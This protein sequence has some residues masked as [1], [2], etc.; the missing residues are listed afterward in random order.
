MGSITAK[1]GVL[2]VSVYGPHPLE[3]RCHPLHKP[4]SHT[5][6]QRIVPPH[7]G[8][9]NVPPAA[10][11]HIISGHISINVCSVVAV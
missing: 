3:F 1:K 7:G 8:V 6:Y 11:P 9:S 4:V 10:L 5:V 2:R